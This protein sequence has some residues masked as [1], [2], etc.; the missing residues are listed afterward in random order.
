MFSIRVVWRSLSQVSVYWQGNGW[1]PINRLSGNAP[2][3][4][5]TEFLKA[6]KHRCPN[7]E[8]AIGVEFNDEDLGSHEGSPL[9]AA[10]EQKVGSIWFS[11][12]E[13]CRNYAGDVS[14]FDAEGRESYFEYKTKVFVRVRDI[15]EV[16]EAIFRTKVDGIVIQGISDLRFLLLLK[17]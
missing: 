7:K 10:L 3:K 16:K 6:L 15:A 9:F 13:A 11:D 14:M 8:Q 2:A 4:D 5:V 17:N 12:I 1:K